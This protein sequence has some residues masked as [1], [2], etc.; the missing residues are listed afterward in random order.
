MKFFDMVIKFKHWK[1]DG[2]NDYLTFNFFSKVFYGHLTSNFYKVFLGNIKVKYLL[3]KYSL[4]S[5]GIRE[6]GSFLNF[7]FMVKDYSL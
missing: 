7:E 3:S 6:A 5:L 2:I 4:N 1:Y